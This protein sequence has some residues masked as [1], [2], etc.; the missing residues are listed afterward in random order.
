M[1]YPP[2]P[3]AY[4][5]PAYGAPA[6][7]TSSNAVIALVLAIA[8]FVICPLV[9]AII[10][11]PVSASARREIDESGGWVTGDGLVQ[12]ARIIA[13]INIGL[14]AASI[15]ITVLAFGLIAVVGATNQG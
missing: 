1:S 12:A 15:V 8:S 7:R 13:W 10:A 3:P 9:P 6:P 2:Q 4:D 11:L 14:V 5:T